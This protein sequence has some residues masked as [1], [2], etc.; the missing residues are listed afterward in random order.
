MD[1][2]LIN[3]KQKKTINATKNMKE[4]EKQNYFSKRKKKSS[5]SLL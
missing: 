5:D 4:N 2:Y 1:W 3:H